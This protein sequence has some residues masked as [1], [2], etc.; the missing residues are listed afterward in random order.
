MLPSVILLALFALAVPSAPPRTARQTTTGSVAVKKGMPVVDTTKLGLPDFS[1]LPKGKNG[2]PI[3]ARVN[4]RE[5][6]LKQLQLEI[7]RFG[8][9]TQS[10]MP[11]PMRMAL[12]SPALDRLIQGALVAEYAEAHGLEVS[13][14]E[15]QRAVEHTNQSRPAGQKLDDD[16][17]AMGVRRADLRELVR[18]Q[19]LLQK[20][21][22]HIGQA[23]EYAP[24]AAMENYL[25][26]QNTVTT[27]IP[28]VR[29]SH[30]FLAAPTTSPAI[31]MTVIQE[32]QQLLDSIRQEK[33]DFA[34]AARR[35]SHEGLTAPSGGDLGFFRRGQQ[36]REIEQAAFALK[37]G[38][39]TGPIETSS[40]IHLLKITGSSP[41]N[42]PELYIRMQR[43]LFLDDWR[44]NALSA[45]TIEKYL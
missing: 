26:S 16:A 23:A 39:T 44:R 25:K 2:E 30:I 3:V 5:I 29:A 33:L 17:I 28:M 45:A 41:N 4:G 1:R 12:A 31:R 21:S 10:P 6:S 42:A 7:A 37:T 15:L 38:E 20:V 34:D 14:S 36:P 43:R 9:P 8:V 32:A 27:G 40:G 18:S 35:Y 24:Q 22:D 13:E 19:I 11:E